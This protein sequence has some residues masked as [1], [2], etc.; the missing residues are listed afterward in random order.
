MNN[1]PP[2]A[3]A[4]YMQHMI[5]LLGNV[6]VELLGERP[7][8]SLHEA[9]VKRSSRASDPTDRETTPWITA[10]VATCASPSHGLVLYSTEFCQKNWKMSQPFQEDVKEAFN[11]LVK[12]YYNLANVCSR[13]E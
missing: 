11:V 5:S 7:I 3:V 6:C 12:V 9:S 10:A 13:A 2:T 8:G 1:E 4:L